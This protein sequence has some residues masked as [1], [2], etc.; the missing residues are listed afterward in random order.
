MQPRK[1]AG[2]QSSPR[3]QSPRPNHGQT[4]KKYHHGY[5]HY[6][7]YHPYHYDWRDYDWYD[8]DWRDYDWYD[9]DWRDRDWNYL[10]SEERMSMP[11]PSS[12]VEN[13]TDYQRGFKD[14]WKAAMEYMMYEY[15]QECEPIIVPSPPIP[16]EEPME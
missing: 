1:P 7:Y 14:G 8:Y 6:P 9:Y 4:K 16:P 12:N 13:Y 11:T 15:Q 2:P 3:P 5:R 10:S